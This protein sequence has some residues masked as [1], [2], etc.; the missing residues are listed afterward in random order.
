MASKRRA[1]RPRPA[2]SPM[3]RPRADRALVQRAA[4]ALPT[5]TPSRMPLL[6][7][8]LADKARTGMEFATLHEGVYLEHL[9]GTVGHATQ[10]YA[11][12]HRVP[13]SQAF[14][15]ARRSAVGDHP[16]MPEQ[17]AQTLSWMRESYSAV[18]FAT[19]S[20]HTYFATEETTALVL[21]GVQDAVTEHSVTA[22]DLPSPDGVAYLHQ[23]DGALV[24]AWSTF[25]NITSV[26][27]CTADAAR[28]Y[29]LDG[30]EPVSPPLPVASFRLSADGA[31]TAPVPVLDGIDALPDLQWGT[32]EYDHYAAPRAIPVFLS[33][34]HMLRQQRLI[35]REPVTA[36]AAAR[37]H[38]SGQGRR[39]SRTDT[40]TYLSYSTRPRTGSGGAPRRR[41]SHR[42]V[43]RGHWR[44]Q[45]YP[46]LQRH[47]PIWIT[48]YI[49]GPDEAPIVLRDKV[50][51]VNAS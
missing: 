28:T 48:D 51:I 17:T 14:D 3:R 31:D 39:C 5:L 34:V 19:K 9:A 37:P 45:W 22:A 24:V 44:R 42:W 32:S 11:A 35:E 41:H 10:L 12:E 49:A 4:M 43:V 36:R 27:I 23:R 30:A 21:A 25:Q 47:V 6:I 2:H 18:A 50:S 38:S 7:D 1:R 20:R 15:A 29:L 8:G 16:Q 26:A 13:V 33:L 40:I 46:S